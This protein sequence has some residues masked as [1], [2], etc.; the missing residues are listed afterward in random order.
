MKTQYTVAVIAVIAAISAISVTAYSDSETISAF[1]GDSVSTGLTMYGHLELIAT[2]QNGNIKQYVQTDNE[3]TEEGA[4][5]VVQKLFRTNFVDLTDGFQDTTGCHGNPGVFDTIYI[6]TA[7][8]ANNNSTA[9]F[10]A[11]TNAT[12]L[13]ANPVEDPSVKLGNFTGTGSTALISSTF[14]NLGSGSDSI[15]QA[16]LINATDA[17]DSG[18]AKSQSLAYREFSSITLNA[19]DQLTINWTITVGSDTT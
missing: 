15:L 7:N 17:E 4:N 2:D 19:N 18:L 12:S 6:G 1:N 14:T 11:I 3:I 13:I 9:T 8:F 5:C 16:I 10:D